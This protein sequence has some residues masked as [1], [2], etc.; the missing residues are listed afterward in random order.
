M[1]AMAALEVFHMT[2]TEVIL[3]ME[4]F[5]GVAIAALEVPLGSC[6]SYGL[7]HM[8]AM[9]ALEVFRMTATEVLSVMG[10]FRPAAM[11]TMAAF[12]MAASG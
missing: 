10:S 1:A 12:R 5:R 9:A 11:A 3:V 2:A 6:I 7:L 8:V 4:S